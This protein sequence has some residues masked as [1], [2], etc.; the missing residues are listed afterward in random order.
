MREAPIRPSG[1]LPPEWPP[2]PVQGFPEILSCAPFA[3]AAFCL[4]KCIFYAC[5]G[6]P[7][8]SQGKK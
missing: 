6:S 5:P 3:G 1:I 8:S 2:R 7:P 4:E